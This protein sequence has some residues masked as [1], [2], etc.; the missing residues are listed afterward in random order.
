MYFG[1]G[2][3]PFA[4]SISTQVVCLNF[5]ACPI[6]IHTRTNNLHLAFYIITNYVFLLDVTGADFL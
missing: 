4:Y 3:V 6:N 2:H 1:H 5:Q